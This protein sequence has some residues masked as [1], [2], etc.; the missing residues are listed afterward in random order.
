MPSTLQLDQYLEVTSTTNRWRRA[1]AARI[2]MTLKRGRLTSAWVAQRLGV[3][4]GQVGFWRAGVVV[5]SAEQCRRLSALLKIDLNW[6]CAIDTVSLA[7]QAK[8]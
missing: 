5:P 6:L 2:D 4:E 8:T 1:F 3:P 7:P